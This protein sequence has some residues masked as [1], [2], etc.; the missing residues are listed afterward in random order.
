MAKDKD[1][2]DFEET[3][4]SYAD[5]MAYMIRSKSFGKKYSDLQAE[6]REKVR[7]MSEGLSEDEDSAEAGDGV[8]GHPKTKLP[9]PTPPSGRTQ[10]R[11]DM[12][13]AEAGRILFEAG[14]GGVIA[15]VRKRFG[16]R[17]K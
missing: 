17:T 3:A 6:L 12:T 2:F 7:A 4:R 11:P 9:K 8:Q 14:T 10:H 13:A 15:D 16:M 1:G 5:M